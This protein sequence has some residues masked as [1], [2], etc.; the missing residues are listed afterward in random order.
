MTTYEHLVDATLPHGLMPLVVPQ[1]KTITLGGAVTGLGIESTSFRHGL[2]H[3]S[4]REMDVLTAD[5]EVVTATPDGE[6]ADLFRGFPN[7]Y[8]TLGYALRLVIDLLPVGAAT[9]GCE[10]R[11]V[12]SADLAAVITERRATGPD[13]LDF[14]DGTV[15]DRRRAVPDDRPV[16]R[17]PRP[18]GASDYTGQQIFYRSI[19]E[20]AVDHLTVHDYLWRWDT[21]WFWCSRAFGV[22]HPAVRR[23]WPRRYRRSDVY[24][25]H[26]RAWTG[27]PGSP[28]GS[29]G[30]PGSRRRSRSSR[31]SRSRWSGSPSSSTPSTATSAS[32]RCGCARCGCAASAR[33]RC[34]RCRRASCTS[35]SASGRPC[36]SVPGDPEAHNRRIERLVADLG[37]HKSLYST[38]HYSE[39]EFWQHYNGPAY[40]ALKQRY[41]PY[42]RLPDLYHKVTGSKAVSTMQVA[43]DH[44]QRRRAGRPGTSDRLRRQQGRTGQLR[45]GAADHLAAGARPARHGAGHARAGP[46]VRRGRDRGGGRPLRAARRDGRPHA[47]RPR[48]RRAAAAGP[49]AAAD[50]A[51]PPASRR[52]TLE[53][54]PAAGG[55]TPSCATRGRSAHHYDVSNRFYEWVLGP[56]MAYTCAVLPDRRRHARGGAGGQVR[57]GGAEARARAGHAAA[58][59][60]LRLGR[61][62]HAR[63]RRA[64]R[65]GARR[66]ALAQPGR[67][68]AGGDRAPGLRRPG[69]GAPPRLPRRARSPSSTRSAR[70]GSPSTSAGPSCRD[71]FASLHDPAA[72]GRAAAQPLH[73]PAAHAHQGGST[74]SSTA[75][76][77]RTASWS[78]VGLIIA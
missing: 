8:G 20:R 50:L 41:D 37:G 65:Q 26:G 45:A 48:P 4:V 70:S 1:L 32:P 73:H 71:Y 51:A 54:R 6:H 55:C 15:F 61:H 43:D 33:G 9:S 68:G 29:A 24:R 27:A 53:Y 62:G 12:A 17:R 52:P 38:V 69:R 44:L 59:R 25:R 34:T 40:R 58:R 39:A 16:H 64:R 10:H 5:G 42:G 31:T 11:R 66:D 46:G 67:V 35:T 30:S 3:E 2:P 75:T 56:S 21:D 77:S 76:C 74:R 13:P 63:R 57:A 78:A 28:A 22:Q 23:L 72:A 49:A 7:S 14:V 19:R 60:R 36:P 18:P 47:G